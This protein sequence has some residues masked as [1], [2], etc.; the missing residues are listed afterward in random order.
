MLLA[1]VTA[2]SRVR[3]VISPLYC[4]AGSSPVAGSTS[5]QRTTAPA[6]SAVCTH[7]RMFASW[8]RRETITSSPGC[9]VLASAPA[10]RYV[11][12][13]MLGPKITPSGSPP[14]SAATAARQA[15]VISSARALAGKAPPALP[16]PVACARL[17]ASITADGT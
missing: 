3:S 10:M 4:A 5:A 8:S 1:A 2:T 16:R 14:V 17:M 11:R 6:R 12:A 13:V 15:A 7:G 9:Q